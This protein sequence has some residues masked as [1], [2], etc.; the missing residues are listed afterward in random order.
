MV[1][2]RAAAGDL[3]AVPTRRR[4]VRFLLLALGYGALLQLLWPAVGGAYR[5]LFL[6]STRIAFGDFGEG[7]VVVV[8]AVPQKRATGTDGMMY[9][10]LVSERGTLSAIAVSTFRQGYL[11]TAILLALIL[12]TAVPWARRWR[13]L[14]VA[15]LVLH[16]FLGLR[17]GLALAFGF[18]TVQDAS[19]RPA[20]AL[21]DAGQW[22]VGRLATLLWHEPH[23]NYVVPVAIWA[24][25]VVGREPVRGG[26][27]G[28]EEVAQA[29]A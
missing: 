11:P 8:E 6:G 28:A 22:I 17:T 18:S 9:P 21:G 23:M 13:V 4:I 14:P 7:R 3:I 27:S 1:G 29:D 2:A 16:A 26:A 20:L 25:V 19:G 10:R 12:A 5:D 15:L 24:V